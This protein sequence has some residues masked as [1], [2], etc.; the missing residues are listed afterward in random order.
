MGPF[1]SLSF[2][3]FEEFSFLLLIAKSG[4][5]TLIKLLPSVISIIQVKINL[6]IYFLYLHISPLYYSLPYE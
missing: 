5:Q 1:K 4:D 2:F 6:V 3:F